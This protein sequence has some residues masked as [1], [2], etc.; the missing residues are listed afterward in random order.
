VPELTLESLAAR[1]AELERELA[2]LKAK[3]PAVIPPTRDWRSVVGMFEESEFSR[4]MD[5]EIAAMRAAEQQTLDA[6]GER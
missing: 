1:V 6:G 2:V 5:A 4:A 3:P